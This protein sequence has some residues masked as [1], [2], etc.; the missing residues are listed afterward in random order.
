M[1]IWFP[2]LWRNWCRTKEW[3]FLFPRSSK[4]FIGT[5]RT[6]L[7]PDLLP[8]KIFC[9]FFFFFIYSVWKKFEGMDLQQEKLWV[10]MEGLRNTKWLKSESKRAHSALYFWKLIASFL[11]RKIEGGNESPWESRSARKQ[12]TKGLHSSHGAREQESFPGRRR[13]RNGAGGQR[14]EKSLTGQRTIKANIPL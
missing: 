3:I 11:T 8:E 2:M 10:G 9:F 6:G 7:S 13:D 14:S 12:I 5:A 4:N 1:G